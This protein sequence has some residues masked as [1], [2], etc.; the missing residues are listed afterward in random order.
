[1][2]FGQ[3][4]GLDYDALVIEDPRYVRWIVEQPWLDPTITARLRAV[5]ATLLV[6]PAS[7]ED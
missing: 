5:I 7:Q 6:T 4:A 3:Y 1:M 2:S